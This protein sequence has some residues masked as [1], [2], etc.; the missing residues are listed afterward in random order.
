MALEFCCFYKKVSE[1]D[2]EKQLASYMGD[3][4]QAKQLDGDLDAYFAA[5]GDDE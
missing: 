4:Y 3:E 5:G 2:L 1:E